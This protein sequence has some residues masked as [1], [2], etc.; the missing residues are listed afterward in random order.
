M[1]TL[2][3]T[4]SAT[5]NKTVVAFAVLGGVAIAAMLFFGFSAKKKFGNNDMNYLTPG[6]WGAV[7]TTIYAPSET[8]VIEEQKPDPVTP[9]MME[10]KQE[11]MM[12]QGAVIQQD[13]G[14]KKMEGKK[15]Y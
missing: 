11:F 9:N 1:P 13:M 2:T 4:T 8:P 3:P 15:Q 10:N 14:N 6:Y 12:D 5:S 7:D